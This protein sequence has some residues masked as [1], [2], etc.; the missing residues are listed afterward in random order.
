[1]PNVNHRTLPGAAASVAVVA[2]IGLSAAADPDPVFAA[3]EAHH[4]LWQ[5]HDDACTRHGEVERQHGAGST[6]ATRARE[7]AARACDEDIVARDAVIATAPAS[8]AGMLA[9]LD[10]IASPQGFQ[11]DAMGGEHIAAILRCVRAF[12]ERC[13]PM[14]SE[15]LGALDGIDHAEYLVEAIH[16]MA[17]ALD[18]DQCNAVQAMARHLSAQLCEVESLL[19]GEVAGGE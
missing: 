7:K 3:I 19:S 4:R 16:M 15:V 9:Y 14:R 6:A 10:F 2:P 12:A 17:T 11:A 5:A 1:M 18:G 8:R 13:G